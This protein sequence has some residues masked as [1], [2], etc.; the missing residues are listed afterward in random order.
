VASDRSVWKCDTCDTR[1]VTHGYPEE[2]EVNKAGESDGHNGTRED[3]RN[4]QN[5]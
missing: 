3:S 2:G 4:I 1:A 5:K